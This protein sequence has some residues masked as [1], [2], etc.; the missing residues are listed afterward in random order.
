MLRSI[1]I[2]LALS[3]ALFPSLALAY[4]VEFTAPD[5]NQKLN[6]SAPSIKIAWTI[7]PIAPEADSNEVDIWLHTAVSGGSTFDY[8]L[9]ENYTS[10]TRLTNEYDWDPKGVHDALLASGQGGVVLPAGKESYFELRF[11]DMNDARGSGL[12]SEKYAVEGYPKIGAANRALAAGWG[13]AV[14]AA[15]G[16]VVVGLVLI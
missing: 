13:T 6:L 7:D 2:L 16:S 14:I 3:S 15:A 10:S 11:H 1:P 4:N 8:N 5:P 9:E 12:K